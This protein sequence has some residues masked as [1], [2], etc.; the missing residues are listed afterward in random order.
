MTSS[1]PWI[2]SIIAAIDP[3]VSASD[4]L[5]FQQ[6]ISVRR[7]QALALALSFSV[8][9]TIPVSA[10]GAGTTLHG[11]VDMQNYSQQPA[12]GLNR[13]QVDRSADPFSSPSAPATEE[14][15]A[16]EGSFDSQPAPPRPAFNLNAQDEGGGELDGQQGQPIFA[17]G[18]PVTPQMMPQNMLPPLGGQ[19]PNDPDSS[20]QMQIQWELWHRRVAE[21]IFVRFDAYAQSAFAHSRPIACQAAYTVTRDRQIVSVKLLQKSPNIVFNS[22]LLMVLKSMNGNPILEFPPGS[23][24]QYVE[25]TGT[26]SRNYGVQGFKYQTGDQETI[27]QQR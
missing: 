13:G 14:F 6:F 9:L 11:G 7:I 8:L 2:S 19:N 24:R 16:P 12:P 23:R 4:R 5:M 27:R 17:P 18:P 20:Q 25:K 26:F 22:M 3:E 1:A 10:Q 21:A 15:S